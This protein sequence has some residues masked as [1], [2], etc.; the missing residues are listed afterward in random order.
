MSYGWGREGVWGDLKMKLLS[1]YKDKSKEK[2]KIK[3]KKS[4][5]LNIS[6]FPKGFF[7]L[8]AQL[9]FVSRVH[10]KTQSIDLFLDSYSVCIS[11]FMLFKCLFDLIS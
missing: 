9:K 5:P 1:V 2:I 4:M 8:C 7:F 3:Y 6:S 11:I 10:D